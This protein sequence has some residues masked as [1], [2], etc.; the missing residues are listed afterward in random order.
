MVHY[1]GTVHQRVMREVMDGWMDKVLVGLG[2]W[3]I[4][5]ATTLLPIVSATG[6]VTSARRRRFWA[7]DKFTTTCTRY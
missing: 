4:H 1:Y 6:M 3:A 5:K 7:N 2:I